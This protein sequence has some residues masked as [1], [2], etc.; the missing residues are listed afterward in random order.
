MIAGASN[1][2][3]VLSV[4]DV[5]AGR[6]GQR[7]LEG[8]TFDVVDRLRTGQTTGQVVTLLGRSGAG[9]TTLLRILAGL[10][11]PKRGEI[12]ALFDLDPRHVGIVFQDYPLLPHRTVL[13]NLALAGTIGGLTH[14][15]ARRRAAELLERIGLEAHG[16]SY[17]AQ[18]SGGQRQRVAIVQQLVLPRRLLLLDEPFSG[19]DPVAIN[20]VCGLITEVANEHELNTVIIVTHDVRAAVRVSDTVLLLGGRDTRGARI[21]GK[22]DLVELDLAWNQEAQSEA[23]QREIE[24]RF[25]DL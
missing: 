11:R 4:R 13:E 2:E 12:R 7:V 22:Y 1:G 21:I 6:G 17:P 20:D 10:D 23:L 8:V 14:Q 15:R 9:K 5:C 19:L 25:R 18:L 16:A 3:V 24:A